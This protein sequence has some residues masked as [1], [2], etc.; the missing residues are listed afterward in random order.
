MT[1]TKSVVINVEITRRGGV[2]KMMVGMFM[3]GI[4]SGQPRVGAITMHALAFDRNVD[5]WK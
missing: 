4:A 3:K 2:M 5:R 1:D